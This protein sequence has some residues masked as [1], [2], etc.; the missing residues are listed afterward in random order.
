[1]PDLSIIIVNWNTRDLLR[2]CLRSIY[3]GTKNLSFEVFM[4]D[5]ASADGSPEM[6]KKE[7]PQV[8]LIRNKENLGFARGNNEGF[9]RAKGRYVL[10]LNPDTEVVN[11]A[12]LK[13]VQYLELHEEAGAVSGRFLYPDGTFQRYYNRFPTFSSMITKWFLPSKI[14]YKLKPT[15]SYFMLDDDFDKLIEVEQPA[16]ACIM[17]RRELFLNEDFMDE[18]F[19]I[20]FSDVDLCRRIY[21]KG[22]KIFVLPQAKIFH[23]MAKGGSE[24]AKRSLFLYVEYFLSMIDY[25]SKHQGMVKAGLLKAFFSIGF[26]VRS[27]VFLM[28]AIWGRKSWDEFNYALKV[29]YLFLTRRY[30]FS[31]ESALGT[32]ENLR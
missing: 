28:E 32:R 14:S 9:S 23:H 25:F 20:F 26:M 22:L 4:I 2:N 11:D 21:S 27:K 5:N 18:K 19:P 29:F 15:R 13:M 7:F 17:V 6:V 3:D 1:M 10:I 16:G 12:L 30:V 8:K 31:R 24:Q